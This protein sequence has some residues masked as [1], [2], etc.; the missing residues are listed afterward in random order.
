MRIIITGGHLSPAFAVI[1]E[2]KKKGV[3]IFFIGRKHPLEGDPSVSLEYKI[4]K[5]LGIPF[6]GI[7]TG[8]L[9]RRFTAFSLSSLFKIP[10]G[11]FESL[12]WV[13]KIRPDIIL[14]FG[15]YLAVPVAVAGWFWR[16][17]IITHEQ[18]VIS[19]LANRIISKFAHKICVSWPQSLKYFPFQKTVLTG[20]PI[21]KEVFQVKKN[22]QFPIIS[23]YQL[24]I[25]YITGGTVGAHTLNEVVGEILPQ[26]LEKYSLIHQCGDA[27]VYKDYE[28]L[29]LKLTN[30]KPK[31]KKRYFLTKYVAPAD[32]GW[33]LNKADLV[34]SRAGANI[35]TELAV[36]GKPA[37][38][39][40]LP[41]A[42]GREQLENAQILVK[43]GTAVILLQER[44][45]PMSLFRTIEFL[46]KNLSEYQ[47]NRASAIAL[48]SYHR[49][50]A[51][52]IIKEIYDLARKD[53]RRKTK[54]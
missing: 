13:R 4:I 35:I 47:K 45:S 30:L 52:K 23:N 22:S 11:F 16:V 3:E 8:R 44:L 42:G 14:S 48:Y 6:L 36:L 43:V 49:Q 53:K 1:S 39:I 27:R 17:P 7:I 54:E 41:W 25:I 12:W 18:T 19:G 32:I 31:I 46:R 34:V 15:G 38:L 5:D 9:Q 21:R 20:N 33:V 37:I 28:N 24:P 10:L 40:P 50:A 51:K 29:K 26:L 2:L